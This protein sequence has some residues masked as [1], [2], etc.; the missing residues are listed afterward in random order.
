MTKS[1]LVTWS[2]APVGVLLLSSLVAIAAGP[3][4][5]TSLKILDANNKKIGEAVGLNGTTPIMAF[6][7][8]DVVV[9]LQVLRSGLQPFDR[10]YFEED[11]CVGDPRMTPDTESLVRF[12]AIFAGKVYAA[13]TTATPATVN[14]ESFFEPA[15]GCLDT[16][17][18]VLSVPAIAVMDVPAHTPPLRVK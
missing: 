4:N 11:G 15:S 1:R 10:V 12:A 16:A 14:V 5:L 9:G 18:G 3:K 17:G 13:D 6:Q 2:A 8:G 7:V